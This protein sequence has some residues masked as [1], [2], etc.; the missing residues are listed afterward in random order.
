VHYATLNVFPLS[1]PCRNIVVMRPVPDINAEGN[2]EA[3]HVGPSG[4][5]NGSSATSEITLTG[6]NL[7]PH[8]RSTQPL[9]SSASSAQSYSTSQS[10]SRDMTVHPQ[11]RQ[12]A[13]LSSGGYQHTS[14]RESNPYVNLNLTLDEADHLHP[15]A[16]TGWSAGNTSLTANVPPM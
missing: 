5:D 10:T 7:A 9:E 6:S 2:L 3:S 16:I 4:S 14:T 12:M 8:L 13:P 15:A 11:D 1:F